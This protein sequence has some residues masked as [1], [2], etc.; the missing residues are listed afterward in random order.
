MKFARLNAL[1]ASEMTRAEFSLAAALYCLSA[2]W[3]CPHAQEA[4]DNSGTNP[5]VQSRNLTISNEF[6]D[7]NGDKFFN[8]TDFKYTEPLGDGTSSMRWT[9]PFDG[10]N[11]LGSNKYG[12]GDISAKLSWV[13]YITKR[14]AFILSAELYAPTATNDLFGTGKW[15]IAPG[16]TW[17]N[18]LSPEVIVA[19][20]YIHNFSFA[21]DGSRTDVNRG[22]FD[23]YV[24]YKPQAKTWWITSDTTVS[25]DFENAATPISWELNFGHLLTKLNNGGA[26]NG[27]IR[28]GIGIGADRP[29]NFNIEVGIS[30]IN[31]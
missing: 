6:R 8:V 9:V 17:A 19:P 2:I 13:P 7:L 18:F 29:Y 10:T 11:L 1:G 3:S 26:V 16:L 14:Q 21:G 15:V 22:D 24:V 23:L 28:P 12:L 27:Y 25:H 4:K 30:V 31:Y 20:A 5:A